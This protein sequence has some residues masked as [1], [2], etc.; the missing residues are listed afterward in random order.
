LPAGPSLCVLLPSSGTHYSLQRCQYS[1]LLFFTPL[2]RYERDEDDTFARQICTS[3]CY[4]SIGLFVFIVITLALYYTIGFVELPLMLESL[5]LMNGDPNQGALVPASL[6]GFMKNSFCAVGGLAVDGA[7]PAEVAGK[8]ITVSTFLPVFDKDKPASAPAGGIIVPACYYDHPDIKYDNLDKT[9]LIPYDKTAKS[10]WINT[11]CAK[12]CATPALCNTLKANENANQ[13][14][15]VPPTFPT[16]QRW[17]FFV[18]TRHTPAYSQFN[19]TPFFIFC[20]PRLFCPP[21][22]SPPHTHTHTHTPAVTAA[23]RPP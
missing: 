8:C 12:A 18:L 5:V 7:C 6:L 20:S 3:I 10:A 19:R 1:C 22:P 2:R 23:S 11:G 15:A 14:S 13:L 9:G 21:P 17:V 16:I 4:T